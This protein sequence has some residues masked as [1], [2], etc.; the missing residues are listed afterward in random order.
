MNKKFF[1]TLIF[2]VLSIVMLLSG[3]KKDD[4]ETNY[5]SVTDSYSNIPQ[6]ISLKYCSIM[7]YELT[8]KG[9]YMYYLMVSSSSISVGELTWPASKGKNVFIRLYSEDETLPSGQYTYD[10][11]ASCDS[12]TADLCHADY[13][14]GYLECGSGVLNIIHNGNR[15]TL[16][17]AFYN[18]TVQ[19][20]SV[21]LEG[22]YSGTVKELIKPVE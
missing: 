22:Y 2:G 19:D 6:K 17:F 9:T 16:D 10:P 13:Y 3:C 18:T 7:K 21:K 4:S 5:F 20:I 15:I 12:F 8:N 1:K 11:F 14:P